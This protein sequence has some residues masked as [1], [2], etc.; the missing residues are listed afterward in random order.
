[1]LMVCNLVSYFYVECSSM[2][3]TVL[4]ATGYGA[5]EPKVW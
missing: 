1:M 2:L 4:L 5:A 3:L